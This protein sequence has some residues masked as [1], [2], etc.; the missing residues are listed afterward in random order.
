VKM[1]RWSSRRPAWQGEGCHFAIET[2]VRACRVDQI[3]RQKVHGEAGARIV[4][5][6]IA[7]RAGNARSSAFVI[8]EISIPRS[9]QDHKA[10]DDATPPDDRRHGRL[11]AAPIVTDRSMP[12]SSATF[13][14]DRRCLL[15]EGIEYK[16]ILYAGI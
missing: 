13:S 2:A 6:G 11:L 9:A 15:R 7:H 4:I 16:G 14:C 3:M 12:K 5:E 8:A 10:V 1:S